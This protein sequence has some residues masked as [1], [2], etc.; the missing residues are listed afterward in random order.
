M[1]ALISLKDLSFSY[2]NGVEVLKGVSLDIHPGER[3]ALVGS[4]GA[5]KSTL[6][7]LIT[8][9]ERPTSGEVHAFGALREKERDFYDVRLKAGFVFQDPDDQLFSPTVSEDIAFGPLNQGKSREEVEAIVDETLSMLRLH[10][11]KDRITHKLSGGQKRLVA[12][13]SVL[14]LKPDVLL[15][16]EPTNDLDR[17]TKQHLIDILTSLPQAI[18][19]IS[20]NHH[21]LKRVATR[22]VVLE[23]GVLAPREEQSRVLEES[24]EGA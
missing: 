5:G 12:I 14:A 7:R 9:L 17:E 11:L 10:H 21:F 16:D 1:T 3:I 13:A 6:L 23:D 8:G 19:I 15:L 2:P 24:A 20:H 22:H 4:N 18:L